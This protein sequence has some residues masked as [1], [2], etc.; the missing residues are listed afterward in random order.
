MCLLFWLARTRVKPCRVLNLLSSLSEGS[1]SVFIPTS[2]RV[3]ERSALYD[4][5][6]RYGFATLVTLLDSVPFASHIPLLL[7]REKNLL[8]GHLS[9]ANPHWEAFAAGSE[10]LAI[11]SGPHA[12][13][14]PSWYASS[15]AVPTWN[16]TAVHI[17][18]LPQLLPPE[19]T[20]EIVNLT[21]S[22]YEGSRSTP[23]PNEMPEDFR[24]R[25]L[26]GI[27]AFEMPI[28]RLEGKF[29][30]GQNRSA[31]DQDGML[32]GLRKDGVE[33]NLLAE[34]IVRQRESTTAAGKE[35]AN[36]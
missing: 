5:V 23:W 33:A 14:S 9:K 3:E 30:L 21:V 26:A 16:Y 12:Y 7:E 11:F 36:R 24:Q 6:E 25:L 20:A 8:L 31:A 15:P 10:S 29:K 34:F 17:Y 1:D 2:F 27:V 19:R 28:T 35:K 22:K 4:F 13:I 18:G 32:E